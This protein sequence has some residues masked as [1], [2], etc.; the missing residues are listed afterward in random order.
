M[1]LV[2]TYD[3]LRSGL[4]NAITIFRELRDAGHR[5]VGIR[6]DSGDLAYLSK[7]AREML[8]AVGFESVGICAS[9]DLDEHL[10]RDLKMQG[11]KIDSWGVGTR[12]I[13]SEDCPALGGVYKMSAEIRGGIVTPKMKLSD[14][15]EKTTNPGIKKVSRLYDIAGKAIADLVQLADEHIDTGRPLTIFDPLAPYKRMTLTDFTARELL[16]PIFVNGECVY[17]SPPVAEIRSYA[18][19][20]L[21][22]FWDEYK[23]VRN[24]HVYKVDLSDGLYALKQRM[25]GGR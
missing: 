9:G 12:L 16:V 10:I 3:T 18:A 19:Q 4:P 8:D 11:A 15:P 23:R 22:T 7:K 21:A 6:L 25:L 24:P 13:T 5:P 20:E 17:E 2:D 14:N 1:L